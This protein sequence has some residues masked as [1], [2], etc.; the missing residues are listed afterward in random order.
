M[1]PRPDCDGH[2]SP[3]TP[4]P[5]VNGTNPGRTYRFFNGDAVL[6]FGFGL[7]YTNFTYVPIVDGASASPKQMVVSLDATRAL[8]AATERAGKRFP[9]LLDEKTAAPHLRV[10]PLTI[11]VTNTGTVDSDD[12]VLG[13]LIP[14]NAGEDG[15]P[16]SQLF[17]FQRVH[18][19]A[20]ASVI[21]QL[22]ASPL[23]FTQVGADGARRVWPGEYTVRMGVRETARFGQG[24]AE[25]GL[26]AI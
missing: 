4:L 26:T 16:L 15:V 25:V 6:P 17:D 21:V 3:L 14:P 1:Y 10:T 23:A 19:P 2:G 24:Y 18:I 20:G 22:G 8:L 13:F 12:V 7:A 5:C 9:S 11:N